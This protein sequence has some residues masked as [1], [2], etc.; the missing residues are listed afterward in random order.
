MMRRVAVIG[1]GSV[2]A[3]ALLHLSRQPRTTVV[4]F[5]TYSPGHDRAAAG[6]ENRLITTTLMLPKE[7][8]AV[9][10]ESL[11][12]WRSLED[13]SGRELIERIGHL[14]VGHKRSAGIS[15]LA[16]RYQGS[17]GVRV[18]SASG[19]AE[20][21]GFQAY[22]SED[23][24]VFDAE[25]GMIR[26]DAAIMSAAKLACD[27]GATLNSNTRVLQLRDSSDGIEVITAA[28]SARFDQVI[29]A[30]GAW[31]SDLLPES[32][33]PI[34]VFRPVSAWYLPASGKTVPE[35]M[36]AFSRSTPH[37]FYGAP[38]FDRQTV[39]LGYS[40]VDQ[41]RISGAPKP[42]DYAIDFADNARFDE[43]VSNYFPL[44]HPEPVRKQAF[45][46]GYTLST[47]PVLQR[48]AQRI[49]VAAGFSGR[50]FKF[51]PA[52]GRIAAD[53][54]LAN[55]IAPELSFVRQDLPP[56]RIESGLSL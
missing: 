34:R 53:L 28:G 23:L 39:K 19:L 36:C 13:A 21:F 6:G 20:E 52:F 51:A 16:E 26:T 8:D 33:T 54:A 9:L 47:N 3:F 46:E 7:Y 31:A 45:F 22:A 42:S 44:L 5:E 41:R 15:G 43:I 56:Q 14:T 4:G 35:R 37:Q 55:R 2:G 18:L 11:E 27:N 38:S 12:A 40:G 1:V 17:R 24:G 10:S 29:V 48:T 30:T 25:G 49:V 50:G 32:A